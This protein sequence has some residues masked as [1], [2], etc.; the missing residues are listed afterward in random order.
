MSL[1]TSLGLWEVTERIGEG[2]AEVLS[3][4]GLLEVTENQARMGM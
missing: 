2:G 4:Q 3:E 1:H